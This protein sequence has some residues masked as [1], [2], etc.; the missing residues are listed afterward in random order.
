M[1][2][3]KPT[4]WTNP[5]N[6]NI[7]LRQK[8]FNSSNKLREMGVTDFSQIERMYTLGDFVAFNDILK[9]KNWEF[10]LDAN[11]DTDLAQILVL[12]VPDARRGY[13]VFHAVNIRE[14]G[15]VKK[16]RCFYSR[17]YYARQRKRD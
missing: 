9:S 11:S 2:K 4:D 14:N 15:N 1:E 6:G 12:E 16:R 13:N 5:L 10:A 3:G 8:A 17:S 7:E